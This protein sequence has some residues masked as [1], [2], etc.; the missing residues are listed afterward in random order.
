MQIGFEP[1]S[2]QIKGTEIIMFCFYA[3]HVLL[4]NKSKDWVALNQDNVSEW[5][6][7][8]SSESCFSELWL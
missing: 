7:I 2:C 1:Q 8:F 4:R 3:K 6:D 5:S